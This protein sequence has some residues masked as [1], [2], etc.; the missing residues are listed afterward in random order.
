[1]SEAVI[2]RRPLR[3]HEAV[4]GAQILEQIVGQLDSAGLDDSEVRRD[5]ETLRLRYVQCREAYFTSGA[6]GG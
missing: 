5:L 1:M 6:V 2:E 4:T 3:L